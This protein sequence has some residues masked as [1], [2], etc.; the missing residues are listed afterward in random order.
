M[1]PK[2]IMASTVGYGITSNFELMGQN[3][4]IGKWHHSTNPQGDQVIY[5]KDAS[6][7]I[8]NVVD[9][10]TNRTTDRISGVSPGMR[11]E[12]QYSGMP[13]T[14]VRDL[15]A[16]GG[17][18]MSPQEIRAVDSKQDIDTVG[19]TLNKLYLAP[20]STFRISGEDGIARPMDA[21]DIQ[22]VSGKDLIPTGFPGSSGD[23]A[24][25]A[26][27]F[28]GVLMQAGRDPALLLKF[29]LK[30]EFKGRINVD[31]IFPEDGVGN[32][33]MQENMNIMQGKPVVR[34]PDDLDQNHMAIHMQLAQDKN[35][36][37]AVKMNP[38]LMIVLQNHMQEHMAGVNRLASMQAG[39]PAPQNGGGS[40][41][42]GMNAQ[43]VGPQ[44][45][46]DSSREKQ[47]ASESK[48][49]D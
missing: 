31:Q 16:Q 37:K 6:A 36:N 3:I 13:A 35:F 23:L 39:V 45:M 5:G 4:E 27:A 43:M 10:Y 25:K 15:I 44:P 42:A 26:M 24:Q 21:G 7:Q 8:L 11:G 46:A 14:A 28:A 1:L 19:I 33:P 9:W 12:M 30:M 38:M 41:P 29:A 32:D 40:G 49:A 2:S 20:H 48:K 18:R 47:M 17:T 22:G 34:D